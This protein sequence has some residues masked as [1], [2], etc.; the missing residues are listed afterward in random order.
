[1]HRWLR[2]LWLGVALVIGSG[3]SA[4]ASADPAPDVE[5]S[6]LP[7]AAPSSPSNATSHLGTF[8]FVIPAGS[9]P[10]IGPVE[11]ADAIYYRGVRLRRAGGS[12][13]EILCMEYSPDVETGEGSWGI[14]ARGS[15]WSSAPL[16]G[17]TC[18]ARE[19]VIVR[20]EDGSGAG[21]SLRGAECVE[22]S[23]LTKGR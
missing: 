2:S 8:R 21:I 23:R 3:G 15:F 7:C 1:M 17:S 9:I 4:L 14:H 19:A 12:V 13:G 22:G 16:G 11:V 5:P 20:S 6:S 10:K 18:K